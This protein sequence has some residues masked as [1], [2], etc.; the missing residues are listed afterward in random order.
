MGKEE[1]KG[2]GKETE[3][4]HGHGMHE[5][6]QPFHGPFFFVFIFATAIDRYGARLEEIFHST[7]ARPH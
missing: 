4:V 3:Q 2:V 7:G 1:E 6:V 5:L